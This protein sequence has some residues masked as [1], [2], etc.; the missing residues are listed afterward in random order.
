MS[1]LSG[2]SST[3]VDQSEL[4]ALLQKIESTKKTSPST[5]AEA[6]EGPQKFLTDELEKQGYSGSKLS[7]LL[8]KI[9][10][11]VD[12]LQNS[13]TGQVDSS[14][15]HDAI[16]KVLKDA[17]VDTDQIDQDFQTQ[18]P[19]G[20]GGPPP[21]DGA[22]ST[23]NST[24]STDTLLSALGIDPKQFQAALQS[25]LLNVSS[26]GTIDLSGLFASAGTGSQINVL[27]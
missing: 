14:K 23:D 2:V 15:I 18:H 9:Q 13:S 4:F 25:A 16:N 7:D 26:D 27:A 6:S 24:S 1:S 8:T 17:G 5:S 22:S 21:M 19:H 10:S 20:P 3:A 12:G 11:A